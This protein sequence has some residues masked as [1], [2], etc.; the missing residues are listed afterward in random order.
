MWRNVWLK[1]SE[2]WMFFINFS[3]RNS[4]KNILHSLN[5]SNTNELKHIYDLG[6][7]Y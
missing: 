7:S 6:T 5:L 1:E 4:N 3:G 2:E